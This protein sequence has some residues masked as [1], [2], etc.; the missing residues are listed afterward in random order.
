MTTST[1][2]NE[3]PVGTGS[4]APLY[5]SVIDLQ[6]TT[7]SYCLQARLTTT[8]LDSNGSAP[9]IRF[10]TAIDALPASVATAYALARSSGFVEIKPAI[11][12]LVSYAFSPVLSPKGMNL[13]VW[14]N[15]VTLPAAA[16]L[17]VELIEFP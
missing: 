15:D 16:T 13:Y 2:Q 6:P 12:G 8:S 7:T 14:V 1:I 17:T 10:A 3:A 4:A 9:E 5:T 11:R